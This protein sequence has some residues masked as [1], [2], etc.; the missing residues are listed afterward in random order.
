MKEKHT[1]KNKDRKD[2]FLKKK[3]NGSYSEMVRTKLFCYVFKLG[4]L[5]SRCKASLIFESD[6]ELAY[7]KRKRII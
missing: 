3:K 4:F 5:Q 1:Q 7:F 6:L 2:F